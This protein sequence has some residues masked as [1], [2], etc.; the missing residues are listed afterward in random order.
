MLNALL[1]S[2]LALP[3]AWT[4]S[5]SLQS[6]AYD[7][8][9]DHDALDVLVCD[10]GT[11]TLHLLGDDQDWKALDAANVEPGD[12]V[13][14]TVR[15][16]S[17]SERDAHNAFPYM[18]VAERTAIV[19]RIISAQRRVAVPRAEALE[20][21]GRPGALPTLS[22]SGRYFEG[23]RSLR[24][25][26]VMVE[27]DGDF[28][29][30][31]GVKQSAREGWAVAQRRRMSELYAFNTYGK[32][33][34][35]D[36][37]SQVETARVDGADLP[38]TCSDL[39]YE[40]SRR[41]SSH[42]GVSSRET[43]DA[44]LYYL[45][46]GVTSRCQNLFGLCYPGRLS[47][48]YAAVDRSARQ[49]HAGCW[50]R[51]GRVGDPGLEAHE[52]GHA[53]GLRHAAGSFNVRTPHGE[54]TPYGDI[55]AVM[56]N[57]DTRPN[58]LTAPARFHLG[59]LPPT[60]LTSS[61]DAVVPL[62]ALSLGPDPT[63]ESYL[64]I[65]LPCS[66]CAP[67]C[68]GPGCQP[69]KDHGVGGEI[70]ISLR[71]DDETCAPQHAP[72]STAYRCHADHEHKYNRVTIH[73]RQP[74]RLVLAEKWF[75][76]GEGEH[77]DVP[78]S[79]GAALSSG[80]MVVM[81]CAIGDDVARVAVATSEGAARGKCLGQPAPPP[82]PSPPPSLPCADTA[83]PIDAILVHGRP[84]TCAQI[85]P[86]DCAA[87][88]AP[89]LLT[90]C[91]VTCGR[92]GGDGGG[93]DGGGGASTPSQLMVAYGV[94]AGLAGAGMLACLAAMLMLRRQGG[95][96]KRPPVTADGQTA[97]VHDDLP[98]L[99]AQQVQTV[100]PLP[101]PIG[102]SDIPGLV[103]EAAGSGPCR[104]VPC[105]AVACLVGCNEEHV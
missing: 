34:F 70:W 63:G 21:G 85:T 94:G 56:G 102:S 44:V 13:M 71:G 10:T 16:L 47:S 92:C 18:P 15:Q 31:A 19:Y 73:Y 12:D 55:S 46:A 58:S 93:G 43:I 51:G 66:S 26:S 80:G 67:R 17:D 74:G 20:R 30:Y 75:W 27:V 52:L 50:V 28:A 4:T 82:S 88:A 54:L 95:W 69:H 101:P 87:S 9:A 65:A 68:S 33:T 7:E 59:V 81:A 1:P 83:G 14:L 77:Y 49:W 96:R 22:D 79:S 61:I 37:L 103:Q 35:D 5:C 64:A 32:L 38:S 48:P 40:I 36:V 23:R 98:K 8:G 84:A 100:A 11:S 89:S 97:D 24:L 90:H 91:P 99:P 72:N 39:G 41:A 86:R 62:R 105:R 78:L 76:L 25:L 104:A 29:E 6:Y 3:S 57:D 60:A 53:L 2:L 42:L 45:P